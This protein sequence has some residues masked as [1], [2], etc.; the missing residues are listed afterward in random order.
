MAEMR[1]EGAAP[2]LIEAAVDHLE[3][4][5]HHGVRRP[6]VLIGGA[7]DLGDERVRI[8]ERDARADAVAAGAAAEDMAEPLTEPAL[9][10]LRGDDDQFVGERV[11]QRLGQ[12]GS[13]TVGEEIGAL[14]AVQVQAHRSPP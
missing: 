2:R 8:A 1:R 12:E 4:R 14:S 9:D 6:R 13:E 5:P 3:Q 7:G 11:G 10:T